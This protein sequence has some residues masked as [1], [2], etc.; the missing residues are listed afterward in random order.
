MQNMGLEIINLTIQNFSDNE[1]KVIDTMA[2]QNV[3]IKE[4]EAAIAKARA[5]QESNKAQIAA[6]AAI[7]EQNK[8][9]QLLQAQYKIEA[10]QEKAKA[11]QAYAIEQ[12]RVRKEFEEQRA[13]AELTLLERATELKR[14]EVEIERERLI[15]EVRE[16]AAAEKDALI[17]IL[18]TFHVELHAEKTVIP[19]RQ[20]RFALRIAIMGKLHLHR[21]PVSCK[22]LVLASDLSR[23]RQAAELQALARVVLHRAVNRRTAAPV[24]IKA[25]CQH[26]FPSFSGIQKPPCGQQ[27]GML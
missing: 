12:E 24:R 25:G 19:Q 23:P 18:H 10:D 3:V 26:G 27:S 1:G 13:A 2:I 9:L 21:L 16:K 20:Q 11:D 17:F 14:Q 6:Q 22:P 15:V 7:A 5:E 8:Q 4:Q